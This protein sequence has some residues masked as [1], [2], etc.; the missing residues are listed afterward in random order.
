MQRYTNID[1]DD[2]KGATTPGFSTIVIIKTYLYV[3][4]KLVKH[5]IVLFLKLL[6]KISLLP[7]YKCII[8]KVPFVKHI[9]DHFM[10]RCVPV[11]TYCL[12]C[13]ASC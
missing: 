3:C 8:K 10:S 13:A 5:V 6:F 2:N 7:C 12:Q 9:D 11:V 1:D 4:D